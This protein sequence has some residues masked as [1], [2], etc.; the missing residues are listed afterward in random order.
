MICTNILFD[1]YK[2][3]SLPSTLEQACNDCRKPPP[4]PSVLFAGPKRLHE[5]YKLDLSV[6]P[7]LQVFYILHDP[8]VRSMS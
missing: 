2:T 3:S 6:L 1:I 4:R 7:F 8:S 5:T